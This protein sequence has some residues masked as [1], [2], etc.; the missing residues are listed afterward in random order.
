MGGRP[1][2]LHSK[3]CTRASRD[4]WRP[5][6]VSIVPIRVRTT[7]LVPPGIPGSRSRRLSRQCW[8]GPR[9]RI[10]WKEIIARLFRPH[11]GIGAGVPSNVG[12]HDT[13]T[14]VPGRRS[15]HCGRDQPPAAEV[16]R[17][18]E[19]TTDGSD[20]RFRF[21]EDGALSVLLAGLLPG[22]N[23][24]GLGAECA[25]GR[26]LASPWTEATGTAIAPAGL[27]AAN[28]GAERE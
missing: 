13:D 14:E 7:R 11:P 24:R 28:G 17:V 20:R 21:V 4:L 22:R 1:G 12:R 15:V 18:N 27:N 26:R 3:N 23:R 25:G 5:S 10:S 16:I 8:S 9:F 2:T 6:S 19:A